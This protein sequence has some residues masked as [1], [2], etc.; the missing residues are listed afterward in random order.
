MDVY[1]QIPYAEPPVGDLRY[2]RP[3]PKSIV[4]DFDATRDPIACA[5]IE[6]PAMLLDFPF[7]EDCL[8]LDVAVPQS[9]V[10]PKLFHFQYFKECVSKIGV[11]KSPPPPAEN[12]QIPIFGFSDKRHLI[13]EQ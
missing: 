11:R 3:V 6:F 1:S 13:F 8:F 9:Q 7:S 4:G 2:A 5:Q 10:Y 12:F